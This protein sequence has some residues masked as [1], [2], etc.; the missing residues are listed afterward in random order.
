MSETANPRRPQRW[1]TSDEVA[2]DVPGY[3]PRFAPPDHES[4]VP[5][6][7]PVSHPVVARTNTLAIV[8]F[9]LSLVSVTLPAIVCAVIARRQINRSGGASKGL[10][11]TTAA[12]I[13]SALW[14][15]LVIVIIASADSGSSSSYYY[16]Y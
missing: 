2:A 12:L 4:Q 5:A 3:G 11:M 10:W 13:I 6:A 15:L 9:V 16:G 7:T 14:I 8:A 1:E